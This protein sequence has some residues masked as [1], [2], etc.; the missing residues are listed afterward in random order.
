MKLTKYVLGLFLVF[1][2]SSAW[3]AEAT[4]P[5]VQVDEIENDSE[6]SDN[7]LDVA[8]NEALE[9]ELE[10]DEAERSPSRVIPTEQISQD[11][12]VSFPV[13]I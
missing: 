11:L 7:A 10:A 9:E 1:S 5:P 2:F 4:T 8:V 3:G 13:D 6:Q 12:G